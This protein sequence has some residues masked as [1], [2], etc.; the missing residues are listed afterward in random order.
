VDYNTQVL[1]TDDGGPGTCADAADFIAENPD[2]ANYDCNFGPRIIGGNGFLGFNAELRIRIAGDLGTTLFWDAT[3]VWSQP[4][5]MSLSFEGES[6]LRQSIG[7]GL[8]YMTPIGP[9]RVE[10]GQPIDA[11][12]ID[13]L[14]TEN[15]DGVI[16]VR[17]TDS[18]KESGKV[19]FSV[20]YPF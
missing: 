9:I 6:G 19:L 15:V 7:V 20:G 1:P 4:H 13:F 12:T 8:F 17:G 14:I 10:Y 18:T 11:R 5:D 16:V 3:Q 2:L